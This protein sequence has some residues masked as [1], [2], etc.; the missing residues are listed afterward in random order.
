MVLVSAKPGTI[1]TIVGIGAPSHAGD[2][3]Q[4]IEACLNEP[5]SLAL[6]SN[7]HLYI[8]DSENHAI[9][10]V[11][12]RTGIIT[13]VAGCP[14]GLPS[15]A[16]RQC[17]PMTTSADL[18]E[19]DP[20]GCS[21][22]AT[23][24]KF[25]QLADL[26]GT[27]RF[28][29]GASPTG[30]RFRGDGGPASSA[31]LNFP[32]AVAVDER[33]N[34]YI[35]DAMNHRVRKVDAVT[36]IIC[37][38]AGTGQRRFSGDG[39]LAIAAALNE[40]VALAVDHRRHLYIADQSNNRVRMVDLDTGVMTTVAGTGEATYN[41]DGM[42]ASEAALAGPSGL[43][44]GPDGTVYIAD[45]FNGRIRAV[46]PESGLIRTVAGDGGEYRYQAQPNEFSTSLSRPYGIALDQTG[47]IV[48]TDSDNH[49][50]RRWD[51]RKKIVTR[52][53]GNGMAQFGGDSGPPQESSLN[54]PFGVAVDQSGNIYIADTF[55]HRIRLIVA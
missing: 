2:G 11:E 13:T 55:N 6:D 37:T 53:A 3:G 9:R 39:G 18:T 26:S 36:G 30:G 42:L 12:L 46:D 29:V 31:T 44:V 51:E 10:K 50:I 45:T 1:C 27:V 23:Q 4:A 43:V 54:Y 33:G 47:N 34:L 40:P 49:L 35:A 41:G 7:G 15:P 16:D 20:L 17:S 25:A 19:E 32:S 38:V 22:Q 48:I 24:E 14:G 52:V 28:V 5:K 21:S 8:A